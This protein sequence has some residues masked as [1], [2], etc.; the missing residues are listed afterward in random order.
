MHRVAQLLTHDAC[1][2]PPSSDVSLV[3]SVHRIDLGRLLCVLRDMLL[4]QDLPRIGKSDRFPAAITGQTKCHATCSRKHLICQCSGVGAKL[5]RCER[6]FLH[7]SLLPTQEACTVPSSVRH[8][9]TPRYRH[10]SPL[11]YDS[12]TCSVTV[13]KP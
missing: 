13:L 2:G 12:D 8:A 5:C 7:A 10:T 4:L 3:I 1:V 9:D 6:D 11:N